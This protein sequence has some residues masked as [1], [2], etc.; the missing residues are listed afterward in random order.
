M[1]SWWIETLLFQTAFCLPGSSKYI[2]WGPCQLIAECVSVCGR[3]VGEGGCVWSMLPASCPWTQIPVASFNKSS[4]RCIVLPKKADMTGAALPSADTP[5]PTTPTPLHRQHQHFLHNHTHACG[6]RPG[7]AGADGV[8][9]WYWGFCMKRI[10][11][12]WW[13]K[14]VE[15]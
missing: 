10:I 2:S 1:F 12:M 8:G 7:S 5:Q 15:D 9:L 3:G 4:E 11:L 14:V 13:L 6:W